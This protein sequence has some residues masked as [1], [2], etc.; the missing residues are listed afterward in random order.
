MILA[1]NLSNSDFDDM[2]YVSSSEKIT[3]F[4]GD[5]YFFFGKGHLGNPDGLSAIELNGESKFG[6]NSIIAIQL[7]VEL[8]AFE[9][10][11]ICLLLGEEKTRL[12]CQDKAYQY[13]KLAHC[14]E[15]LNKVKR[16]WNELIGN[17]QVY[18]PLEST[19]ILLNGW[20]IYQT[21]SCRLWARTGFYQSGG[22]YGFR[23]Q[24][25][26]SMA[27]KYVDSNITRNQIIK[28]SEHQFIE[29]D[30]EHWW[31]EETEKG[32]RTRFSD[33]LLWL[34][35]VTADYIKFTNDYSILDIKTKYKQGASLEE[36]IDERYDKYEYSDIEGTIYEHS[37]KAI[38]HSFKFGENGLPKIGSGDWN[39][40]F[41][42]VGNKGKG[43]SVWLRILFV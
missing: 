17:L 23:D 35:F 29:G 32:I 20:A 37:V 4:T 26:D 21:L 31:H 19:N 34:P 24:L 41:S 40:G 30:V 5:K 28:H 22:A 43:E 18:T 15:E 39:D 27:I 36:G 8:E 12:E 38:E 10:K 6:N 3:S 9:S 13:M 33:D 11:E 1:K 14:N 42:T 25:Q 7:Q 2:Y 16:F